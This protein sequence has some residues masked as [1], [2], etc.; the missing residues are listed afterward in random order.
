MLCRCYIAS[1][2]IICL[3]TASVYVCYMLIKRDL[4]DLI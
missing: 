3:F 4:I 2:V 1:T